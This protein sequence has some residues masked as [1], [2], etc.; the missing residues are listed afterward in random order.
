MRHSNG[1]DSLPWINDFVKKCP[2]CKFDF[3]DVHYYWVFN[4]FKG[5]VEGWHK[6]FP[7]KPL[8][9][10][11]IGFQSYPSSGPVCKA[12]DTTCVSNIKEMVTWMDNT[13]YI[14]RYTIRGEFR[15][16]GGPSHQPLWSFLDD[17]GNY[18]PLGKWYL[19]VA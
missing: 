18:T 11:D 4:E 17:N 1:D 19:G 10:S 16:T 15:R 9:I 8:W 2:D 13:D 14:N 12:A 5:F 3:V 7:N 6:R